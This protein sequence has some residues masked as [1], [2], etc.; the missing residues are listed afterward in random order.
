MTVMRLKRVLILDENAEAKSSLL[1]DPCG[2][3][4]EAAC[5]L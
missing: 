4:W 3:H 1:L 5:K 2:Q